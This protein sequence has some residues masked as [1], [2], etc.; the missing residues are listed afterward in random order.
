MFF[1]V[2]A[3]ADLRDEC[4]RNDVPITV[5]IGYWPYG[6]RDFAIEDINGISLIFGQEIK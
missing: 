1:R 2:Q 4:V 5:E 3:V 6:V